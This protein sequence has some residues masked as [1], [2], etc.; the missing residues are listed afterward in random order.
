M[1]KSATTF[2]FAS[3]ILWVASG[4]ARVST[5]TAIESNGNIVRKA[6][7]TIPSSMLAMSSISG[8]QDPA[9]QDGKEPQPPTPGDYFKIPA[10]GENVKVEPSTNPN[11]VK[12][13]V[14]QKGTI[15]TLQNTGLTLWEKKGTPL[16]TSSM[17]VKK[18]EDGNWQYSETLHWSGTKKAEEMKLDPELR[19]KVKSV[20]PEQFR[21]TEIIDKVLEA[22]GLNMLYSVFGPPEPTIGSFLV[23]PDGS[24]RKLNAV[25]IPAN[26]KTFMET[27][28]GITEEQALTMSRE[29]SKKLLVNPEKSV[30]DS[31]G[32]NDSQ[33]EGNG[34][35]TLHFEVSF[36]GKIVSTNGIIDPL[37][38][39]VYWSMMA[40]AASP[41]DIELKVVY[42]PNP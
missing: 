27:L 11:E 16:V 29:L 32:D 26:A 17:N 21:K 14:T 30:V 37:D 2:V 18:L 1:L 7:Y 13:T 23:D 25:F 42:Q 40:L 34:M 36:P 12:V 39:H 5:S 10:E 4:C 6:V 19:V 28:E 15:E 22:V 24:V 3:V 8:L 20:L 38:G 35:A 9:S 31:K 33:N 41:K